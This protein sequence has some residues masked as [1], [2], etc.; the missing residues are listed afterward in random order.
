MWRQHFVDCI[1]RTNRWYDNVPEPNRIIG[2]VFALFGV[3]S[4]PALV[5]TLLLGQ[6]GYLVGQSVG[7]VILLAL[8]IQRI[9]YLDAGEMRQRRSNERRA[10]RERERRENERRARR[11]RERE[12]AAARV[13]AA[14]RLVREAT[15][16][17]RAEQARRQQERRPPP[18]P[19]PPPP[20]T[21]D[22]VDLHTLGLAAMPSSRSMLKQAYRTAI[23][24]AHPDRGGTTEKARSVVEA[25]QRLAARV[26]GP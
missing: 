10:Q 19:P 23:K 1:Y 14:E 12:E 18:R 9:Y 5:L 4:L 13:A 15:A 7:M 26:S 20:P 22:I 11:E 8:L 2:A 24:R 6:L 25:Y 21:Q 3:L 16:R 17:A